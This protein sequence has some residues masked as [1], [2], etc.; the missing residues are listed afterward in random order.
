M[1]E[2]PIHKN[3]REELEARRKG[4]TRQTT[5]PTEDTAGSLSYTKEDLNARTTFAR[6]LS[7][8]AGTGNANYTALYGGTFFTNALGPDPLG[9]NDRLDPTFNYNFDENKGL[10]GQPGITQV[11]SEYLGEGATMATKKKTTIN[12]TCFSLTDLTIMMHEFMIPGTE[13]LVDFGWVNPKRM[14]E[15]SQGS[16]IQLLN[17]GIT[18]KEGTNFFDYFQSFDKIFESYGNIET[19]IGRVTEY[20]FSVKDDGSFD[21]TISLISSG[22]SFY[23]NDIATEEHPI[24]FVAQSQEAQE[25]FKALKTDAPKEEKEKLAPD[26]VPVDL[27]NYIASMRSHVIA[28]SDLK[29][30]MP[31]TFNTNQ[32]KG[33]KNWVGESGGLF[34]LSINSAIANGGTNEFTT[35]GK[36]K[37]AYNFNNQMCTIVGDP[38]KSSYKSAGWKQL[39]EIMPSKGFTDLED[40]FFNT[41]S[42]ICAKNANWIGNIPLNNVDKEFQYGFLMD[43]NRD[44][45]YVFLP[46]P[47]EVFK[48][49]N[50]FKGLPY[51]V[52]IYVRLGYFEDNVLTKFAGVTQDGEDTYS[53]R[54]VTPVPTDTLKVDLKNPTSKE[55]FM[56]VPEGMKNVKEQKLYKFMNEP[57]RMVTSNYPYPKDMSKIIMQPC[58]GALDPFFQLSLISKQLKEEGEA[59]EKTNV[60]PIEVYRNLMRFMGGAGSIVK[61]TKKVDAVTEF[62][63]EGAD[64]P[65]SSYGGARQFFVDRQNVLS[66]GYIRNLYINLDVIQESFCGASNRQFFYRPNHHEIIEGAPDFNRAAAVSSVDEGVKNLMDVI[67]DQFRNFNS[68]K[69][70]SNPV[71]P[72]ITGMV[73]TNYTNPGDDIFTVKAFKKDS[74]TTNLSFDYSIPPNVQKAAIFGAGLS[75]QDSLAFGSFPKGEQKDLLAIMQFKETL[76]TAMG[77]KE[78]NLISSKSVPF[79]K[80]PN[81]G[82]VNLDTDEKS[83][84]LKNLKDDPLEEYMKQ[85]IN[86]IE[87]YQLSQNSDTPSNFS[88]VYLS[89]QV[90]YSALLKDSDVPENEKTISNQNSALTSITLADFQRALNTSGND[91]EK[92][93]DTPNAP[94]PFV[95]S[96]LIN[97]LANSDLQ[98]EADIKAL[99][100]SLSSAR[101]EIEK[102]K[103]SRFRFY[104]YEKVRQDKL[105]YNLPIVRMSGN[106]QQMF[107]HQHMNNQLQGKRNPHY[108]LPGMLKVSITLYGIS[109]ILPG[110]KFKVDYLPTTLKE[111]TYFLCTGV[112]QELS[113]EAWTT[114]IEAILRQDPRKVATTPVTYTFNVNNVYEGQT[115]ELGPEPVRPDIPIPTDEE[116][117][118]FTELDIE[119]LDLTD[120]FEDFMVPYS[121]EFDTD[122]QFKR[123][124]QPVAPN[125]IA[126]DNQQAYYN[127]TVDPYNPGASTY[128][129]GQ[130]DILTEDEYETIVS[131]Y[132]NVEEYKE[133][134][135]NDEFGNELDA[136]TQV[137]MW[138]DERYERFTIMDMNVGTNI[139]A[140]DEFARGAKEESEYDKFGGMMTVYVK[141]DPPGSSTINSNMSKLLKLAA[142]LR[143]YT[144]R[145]NET[146][147]NFAQD[148]GITDEDGNVFEMPINV[149]ATA[150]REYLDDALRLFLSKDRN[151]I[152]LIHPSI[153]DNPSVTYREETEFNDEILDVDVELGTEDDDFLENELRKQDEEVIPAKAEVK[154]GEVGLARSFSL[155]HYLARAR[156]G[157]LGVFY[158]EPG[159]HLFFKDSS[160]NPILD[161]STERRIEETERYLKDNP[162]IPKPGWYYTLNTA[163]AL[164]G[165]NNNKVFANLDGATTGI[166]YSNGPHRNNSSYYRNYVRKSE[167]LFVYGQKNV[168]CPIADVN[169]KG[170][171]VGSR[172]YQF[173]GSQVGGQ[174][175]FTRAIGV[176]VDRCNQNEAYSM[177]SE[178]VSFGPNG[179]NEQQLKL[180]QYSPYF[181]FSKDLSVYN[182]QGLTPFYQESIDNAA[183][184]GNVIT[185]ADFAIK[186]KLTKAI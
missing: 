149:D 7:L 32:P 131:Y 4:L 186:N 119:P 159:A 64:A 37:K 127:I 126:D 179:L 183:I 147:V 105:Q 57:T 128:G 150:D 6:M 129:F 68:F 101:T 125:S 61:G 132:S 182:D 185:R 18:L 54:S 29:I 96:V 88:S 165:S 90:M 66:G 155:E 1:I 181:P 109:G 86:V 91:K 13:V 106:L 180:F 104:T 65:N 118:D 30:F 102:A 41:T 173:N 113:G 74:L 164:T 171:E 98:K 95:P 87:P 92:E 51:Y 52:H 133:H 81:F 22:T 62:K 27:I 123:P 139:G 55:E 42:G 35:Y 134:V 85:N 148:D 69:M 144:E 122:H 63:I 17:S 3:I 107:D 33:S 99:N 121:V 36:T 23:T 143:E 48:G 73:D 20:G 137:E 46:F 157:P 11:Q 14:D 94:A 28:S 83:N 82:S 21:C 177:R 112:S 100:D 140:S 108:S 167:Q 44:F 31:R 154:V 166:F 124:L 39:S 40:L 15:I 76:K 9:T 75:G 24:A 178:K 19:C 145:E 161:L 45:V 152:N 116:P 111:T 168:R 146:R 136:R 50:D 162:K 79:T 25:A 8:G 115:V 174:Q 117:F 71:Y 10:T 49:I 142:D 80:Y 34:G 2:T 163:L 153:I 70:Q 5:L 93:K 16:F 158:W 12:F 160:G 172:P 53:F 72:N 77:K 78:D 26:V 156:V 135:N 170:T 130:T 184:M 59:G 84:L 103:G 114:T 89:P 176:M 43:A 138:L 58:G 56:A 47:K 67:N 175:I 38:F 169:G 120:M 110:N 141:K 97:R 151:L 60:S